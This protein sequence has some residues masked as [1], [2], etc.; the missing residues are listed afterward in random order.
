V[1]IGDA[2]EKKQR[3]WRGEKGEKRTRS[4]HHIGFGRDKRVMGMKTGDEEEKNKSD[5]RAAS[6]LRPASAGNSPAG[7]LL[8]DRKRSPMIKRAK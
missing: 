2:T 4:I 6:G 7:G 8:L 5:G 3:D 1:R